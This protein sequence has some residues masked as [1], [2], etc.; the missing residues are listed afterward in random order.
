M[1]DLKPQPKKRRGGGCL[2]WGLYGVGTLLVL[3]IIGA[4]FGGGG[5]AGTRQPAT[6]NQVAVVEQATDTPLP[7][8]TPDPNATPTPVP[9]TNTPE[10]PTAPPLPTDTPVPPVPTNTPLPTDAPAA[11]PDANRGIQFS[12]PVTLDSSGFVSVVTLATNTTNMVK[13][14][15]VKAT[16]KNGDQILATAVGTV[17]DMQPGQTRAVSL[18]S[19]DEIPATYETV[20]ID[21]DTMILETKTTDGAD[22]ARQIVFGPPAIDANGFINVEATN[23]DDSLHTFTVQGILMQG[24]QLVG[25]A[26]GT[27]NDLAPGQT[28]TVT[29]IA[30]G[31]AQGAETRVMVDTMI[32]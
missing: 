11:P 25:I 26:V 30:Q 8:N 27:V 15:T 13:T 4:L 17:N 22:A 6:G 24:G 16:Y 18:V 31:A 7:T 9:P 23:N 1:Y 10:P 21:V 29:M 14:F 12:G 3:G 2:R 32:Q 19:L 5:E 28:K 20:R